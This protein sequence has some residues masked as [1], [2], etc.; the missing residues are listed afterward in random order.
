VFSFNHSRTILCTT[1]SSSWPATV[2]TMINIPDYLPIITTML[3]S[4]LHDLKM[5]WTE[6]PLSLCN[7]AYI[8]NKHRQPG[9]LNTILCGRLA[10][11]LTVP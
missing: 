7:Q 10:A 11:T 4:I 1:I 5:G 8:N 9:W 2:V 3:S 6:I